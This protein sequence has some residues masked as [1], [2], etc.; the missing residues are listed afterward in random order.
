VYALIGK[1]AG[2]V[3]AEHGIGMAKRPYLSRSRSDEEMALMRA[4]KQMLDPNNI[5]SPNKMFEVE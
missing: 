4:M 5:L 2:S 3:S 1:Y